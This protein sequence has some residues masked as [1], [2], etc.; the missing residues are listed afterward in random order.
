LSGAP[1]EDLFLYSRGGVTLN[2]G[3]RATYNVFSSSVAYEHAYEW[4]AHDQ[5]R[6]DGFGS[7]VQGNYNNGTPDAAVV[8]TVWHSIRLKK[9]SKSPW[10]SAPALVISGTK[11]VSQDMLPYTPKEATSSLKITVATDIRASHE[12]RE[13]TRQQNVERRRGYNY[14]L[15]TV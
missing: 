13:V 10:T 8:T 15:V 2:R 9:S 7:P 3:E 4:E 1:E 11:P 6:L 12:E 14:D 5:P